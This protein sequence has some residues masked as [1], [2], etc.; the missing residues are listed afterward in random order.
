MGSNGRPIDEFS[1]DELREYACE[2]VYYEITQFVR[3]TAA[4]E[5]ALSYVWTRNF[6]I[7]VFALHVRNLLDF[8]APRSDK[9]RKTDATAFNFYP[10]W[11]PPDVDRSLALQEARWMADKHVAHLTTSRTANVDE[12]MWFVNPIVAALVPIIERFADGATFVC[13]DF[14]EDVVERIAELPPFRDTTAMPPRP[15]AAVD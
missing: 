2:H 12:K 5:A 11:E 1:D 13:D 6:A 7:E 14:R 9:P 8:F 10:E 3:A 15:D 4:V